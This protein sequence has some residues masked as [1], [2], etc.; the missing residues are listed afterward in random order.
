MK[1]YHNKLVADRIEVVLK[2]TKIQY[3]EGI[4]INKILQNKQIKS[5]TK[6]NKGKEINSS[7]FYSN[8]SIF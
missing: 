8:N 4:I 3:E 2:I 7:C 6:S 5:I 1:N